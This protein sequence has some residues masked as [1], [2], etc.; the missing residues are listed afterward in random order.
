MSGTDEIR[1][2]EVEVT[3]TGGLRYSTVLASNSPILRDLYAALG[4]NHTAE[5]Q[6]TAFLVQLPL[7]GGNI[8]CSFMSTSLVALQTKPPVLVR[9]P[10]TDLAP[11][12]VASASN[13][14]VI[15]DFL[16]PG[17]NERLLGYALDN[18]AMFEV[19][20][21][22]NDAEGHRRSKVLY[23]IKDSKW[24]GV[25]LNRLK[26]HLPYALLMLN[27][28]DFRLGDVEMQLT[29]SNDGDYFKPHADH[30]PEKT[31]TASRQ[32]TYVYYLHREPRPFAG[33]GLLIYAGRP[34]PFVYANS[35]LVTTVQPRNNCLILFASH[36]WHELDV[37]RC[38]S[39]RF[40]DSRFTVN[41]WLHPAPP[42]VS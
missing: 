15:E 2:V 8:A 25:F 32:I 22:T 23:V 27:A 17:E 6:R 7:D 36:R 11:P 13:H 28:L 41:G 3:L 24:Q 39:G 16:T 38:P 26:L 31:H 29:A 10:A 40:A 34:E 30:S 9:P 33:G 5:P 20:G 14:V 18:E 12:I 19:S 1:N 21:V 35:R 42:T 37:V 4:G